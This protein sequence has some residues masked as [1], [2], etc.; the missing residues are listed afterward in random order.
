MSSNQRW[1][2]AL[3]SAASF[4][5]VLDLLIVATA[6]G[7]IRTHFG[8][9][10]AQLEWTINAYTLTFA[11]GLMTAAAIGDRLG[12]R[13]VFAVGLVLFAAASAGCALAPSIDVLIFARVIQGV[14]AATIMPLALAQL[15]AAFP[16]DQ[17][18]RALG[19]Y[20][21]VTGLAALLGPV[22]GG[23]ITHAFAWQWIF[24]LNVPLSVVA[25]PLVLRRMTEGYGSRA[26]LDLGGLALLSGSAFALVWG[27]VRA[28]DAGW[29]SLETVASLAGAA[30]LAVLFVAWEARHRA[31][32]LPLRLFRSRAFSAGNAAIFFLNASLTGAIFFAAQYQQVVAGHGALGAG[33]CLLPWGIAPFVL[34][35]K[36][37]AL[38]DRLGVRPLI[39]LGLS[40][41][42]I[43]MAWLALAAGPHAPY[44]ALAVPMTIGGVGFSLAI[45]AVTKAVV[46]AVEPA[47]IGKASG[48]Y[49][50]LRQL[51]A[52]FGVAIV[53]AAFARAGSY[54]TPEAFNAGFV[55]AV[56][57]AA[58]L[59][60][61]GVV[62]A[63]CLPSTTAARATPTVHGAQRY[64]A[65]ARNQ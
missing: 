9:S 30:A 65:H 62:A 54:A 48:A 35:P 51:G 6:L 19:I 55:V 38:A 64:G 41:L 26:A 1:V 44:V 4:M 25:V 16:A 39:V 58:A 56:G 59:A 34:A 12:R 60:L 31:P 53:V 20:G 18:G 5:V 57:V 2:I 14:G 28:N 17:R 11:T 15:N 36:A 24:W 42:A 13:R 33:L 49:S 52:S 29:T 43:G 47:D 40:L 27:L 7:T 46:G 50:T 32:L 45:P 23:V 37:G 22:L 21:S 8:A 63:L 3:T 10:L 61:A